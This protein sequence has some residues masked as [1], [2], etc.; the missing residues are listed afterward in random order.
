MTE[1]ELERKFLV[2]RPEATCDLHGETVIQIY[3]LV[4]HSYVTRIRLKND[5]LIT[6]VKSRGAGKERE[7]NET[8]QSLTAIQASDLRSALER[9]DHRIEKTRF[10]VDVPES[11]GIGTWTIDVFHGSHAGLILAEFELTASPSTES[12]LASALILL[13][14]V[15]PAWF[16][17]REVTNDVAYRNESLAREGPAT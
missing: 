2:E 17:G 14:S 3:P 7:E 13:D 5:V 11:S 10:V 8:R 9:Y 15:E 1:F 4:G 16:C 12:E 6:T